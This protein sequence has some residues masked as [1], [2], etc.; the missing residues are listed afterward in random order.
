MN[1][2]SGVTTANSRLDII[3]AL[4]HDLIKEIPDQTSSFLLSKDENDEL[5]L[6]QKVL[7]SILHEAARINNSR[8]DLGYKP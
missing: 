1:P 8:N 4:I 2:S 6:E 5:L 7:T 3:I